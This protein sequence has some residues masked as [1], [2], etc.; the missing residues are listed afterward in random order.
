MFGFGIKET[1]TTTGTGTLTLSAVTGFPR[2]S[3]EFYDGQPLNYSIIDG[4]GKPVENGFGSYVASNTITRDYCY[5]KFVSGTWT[6]NPATKV[7]LGT[8]N[9]NSPWIVIITPATQMLSPVIPTVAAGAANRSVFGFPYAETAN[10]FAL[11]ANAP[12]ATCGYFGVGAAIASIMVTVQT[13]AGSVSDRIQVGLYPVMSNGTA[14]NLWARSGDILPN[15][16]GQKISSLN[17]GNK[18]LPPGWYFVV[19]CSNVTPSVS[20][21]NAGG[22]QSIPHNTP[23]GGTSTSNRQRNTTAKFAALSGGWTALPT[24]LGAITGF[25]STSSTFPPVAAVVPA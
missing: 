22:E 9:T 13:A 11:I 23:L 5:G 19:L 15:S 4:T 20:A 14:G 2:V 1:T 7:N 21:A 17:G 18:L 24:S 10:S 6:P 12:I 3:D 16:T 8:D 25:D